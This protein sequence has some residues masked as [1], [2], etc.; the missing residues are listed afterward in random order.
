MSNDERNMKNEFQVAL[1]GS[2]FDIPSGFVIRHS[3]FP[4]LLLVFLPVPSL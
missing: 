2:S 1:A 4:D 3:C